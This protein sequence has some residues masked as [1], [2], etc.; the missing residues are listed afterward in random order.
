MTKARQSVNGQCTSSPVA[1]HSAAREDWVDLRLALY[2]DCL[3]GAGLANDWY[4]RGPIPGIFDV[5]YYAGC[6]LDPATGVL[7]L[8]LQEQPKGPA[9]AIAG[10][11]ADFDDAE[12]LKPGP[13]L[14]PQAIDRIREELQYWTGSGHLMVL[15]DA[16]TGHIELRGRPN[17]LFALD[18]PIPT[19][20]L[21]HLDRVDLRDGT[22]T[23][24]NGETV[25][26]VKARRVSSSTTPGLSAELTAM[27]ETLENSPAVL[28]RLRWLIAKY[29]Q[30]EL[31]KRAPGDHQECEADLRKH[32]Q[33]LRN[34]VYKSASTRSFG[35][36]RKYYRLIYENDLWGKAKKILA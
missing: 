1:G 8:K 7:E 28:P 16:R 10:Y 20:V 15:D 19:H 5:P 22:V 23:L 31:P 4:R 2:L 30:T 32:W 25:Y 33:P 14:S 13:A 24:T 12:G 9:V 3:D 34:G 17:S 11:V 36:A 18:E 26:D 6:S 35:E 21:P 27:L 29:R